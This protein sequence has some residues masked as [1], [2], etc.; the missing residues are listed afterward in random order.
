M[1]I[2]LVSQCDKRALAESRRIL[3][4]FGE[5]RGER[6]W[7]TPIT[8]AG[9]DTLRRLLKKTARKNTSVACHWIRGH[10]HSE[11]LWIVGDASR[12]N[13]QGAVP[14][15]TTERDILRKNDENDWHSGE[16]IRLLTMLAAL[17][18]DLG[19]ACRAFQERL[20]PKAPV[21]RNQYRHEWI[22]LRLFQAF[23]GTDDDRT[24]LTRLANP[25]AVDDAS[26]LSRLQC[27]GLDTQCDKPFAH[28][29]PLASALGWLVLTHHRLPV[30]PASDSL[31]GQQLFLGRKVPAFNVGH[32]SNLMESIDAGWNEQRTHVNRQQIRAYWEFPH[33]LPVT[34]DGWRGRAAKQARRLRDMVDLPGHGD[35]L[36]N[37][38]VMHLARLSLMLAD[39]HYSSLTEPTHR[40]SLNPGYPLFA[41]TDRKTGKPNQTLDEHLLGVEAHSAQVCHALAGFERQLPR[42]ARHR[43]LKKRSADAHFLWQDKAAD[44]AAAMREPSASQ[45]AFIVNMASTGRGK[46]LANARIMYALNDPERGMRC[47]FALGLRSLT[48][49]TGRVFRDL[50]GLDEDDLAIRVGGA[51]SHELFEHQQELAESSGSAS[52]QSLLD[53]DS[54]VRF[55][56]N[57]EADPLLRRVIHEPQVRALLAAPLLVCTV[58]HL[59]P[60]TEAQRG[61]RQIAPMLRLMSGDLVLDEPDD[62]DLADLPALIRLVHW[63]GLL[64][65]RVLLSSATLAPALLKGLFEAYLDGRVHYQRNRGQTPGKA[66]RVICAWID[67]NRQIRQDCAEASVFEQANQ[68]FVEQRHTWLGSQI[69]RRRARLIPLH[70]PVA[71]TEDFHQAFA[72]LVRETAIQLHVVHNSLDP[73]SGKRVSFGLVR[74]AN[75][76]PLYEVAQALFRKGTPD[77]LRIH[78]C[79]YHSQY[80]LLLRSAIEQRLDTALNRRQSDA[81]FDVPD[82][83]Q[84]LD[85][86]H[87][88]DHLFIVLGSPVTEVGRDHD[89]DWA[90]V[91]PSSMRSLIQLAGRVRRHR[92]DAC[93]APNIALLDTNLRHLQ[94]PGEPGFCKPGFE[95]ENWRLDSHR[96]GDLLTEQEREIIDARPRILA[97]PV[98]QLRPRDSL[99]DLEHARLGVMMSPQR[100]LQTPESLSPRERKRQSGRFR[101]VC[102]PDWWL[103]PQTHLTF[104]LQQHQPFREDNLERVDLALIPNEGGD[105]YR[106]T[107]I[108]AGNHKSIYVTVDESQN[109]RIPNEALAGPGICAWGETGYL[110]ALTLLAAELDLP[111]EDC[112]QRFGVLSLPASESGWQFNPALGFT[113]KK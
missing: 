63:A 41:N 42:L 79:V 89:Y 81:V 38:Y 17:L 11:L 10:G 39:H 25:S 49:Q 112:A 22:S 100:P 55:E 97:R 48:L 68:A 37:P 3:D 98:A 30:M 60:A 80:P 51:A 20:S 109:R 75:I 35:W 91:E 106:L 29:P 4:Q 53:E 43:G 36:S 99:V 9:L 64:G 70:L 104:V 96:L 88:A 65:A 73:R 86:H 32:L 40:L 34:T 46:T 24:W 31:T 62:F 27:D 47:A 94:H 107:R 16:A 105:D 66:P 50:L 18:H 101:A 110:E 90:V 85:A 92:P 95:S 6:T 87:E 14:T 83:R 61:G 59:T 108:D 58:D 21:E 8:L 84:R 54:Y 12:F 82:I 45:G 103:H 44:L 5:R 13:A 74:M 78:L 76:E 77:G 72:D 28:L 93:T 1:N 69:V 15:N 56:G 2:L 26:W 113:R 102:A 111:L 52:T 23:V 19:K 67:E 57:A 71:G 33:G 7:Q